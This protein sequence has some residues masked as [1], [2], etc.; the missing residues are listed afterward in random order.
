MAKQY[1]DL[2]GLQ[3]FFNSLKTYYADTNVSE[4]VGYAVKAG[5]L[6]TARNFSITGAHCSAGAVAFNGTGDV[7][8]N[9]NIDTA[10]ETT[11]G[12]MSA[13]DFNKLKGI[14]AGAQ[15]NKIEKVQ[16]AT[17]TNGDSSPNYS[18]LTVTDK[19][20][21]IDLTPY[22][23]KTDITAVFKFKGVKDY[24]NE[25]DA[26]N[27]NAPEGYTV[28]PTVGVTGDVW[29]VNSTSGEYVWANGKWEELGSI[30][31][32]KGYATE[33]FVLE[34]VGEVRASLEQLDEALTDT[35]TKKVKK[36]ERA[37]SAASADSAKK[38]VGTLTVKVNDTTSVT[39]D[40]SANKSVDLSGYATKT[41][42]DKKLDKPVKASGNTET[43]LL[44]I[45]SNGAVSDSQIAVS[46]FSGGVVAEGNTSFVTGATVKGA[47][48]S[49]ISKQVSTYEF[50]DGS[51]TGT[52]KVIKTTDG[53]AVTQTVDVH[54]IKNIKVD[55]T[56]LTIAADRSVD[57]TT[58]SFKS[59]GKV[60]TN[61]VDSF[62]T[63]TSSAT[64]STDATKLVNGKAVYDAL[65]GDN[66]ITRIPDASITAMFTK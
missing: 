38:T 1:L 50:E 25:A 32:F 2:T 21:K 31:S 58:A 57:I 61:V 59:F 51:E 4:K 44:Q 54:A 19:T 37:D 3:S 47:I 48:D 34:K 45:A 24:V 30:V 53:S 62:T 64:Y 18:D 52:F 36:A 41:E 56:A 20:V 5:Q 49:A 12:L 42:V 55:G 22:A 35:G 11:A 17:T 43:T 66:Y 27:H 39:F 10:G 46:K 65:V 28:L 6:N 16:V 40:G 8:L 15:V 13:A 60:A 29:H 33:D 7:E 63:S 9:L 23:L 26:K 14:D